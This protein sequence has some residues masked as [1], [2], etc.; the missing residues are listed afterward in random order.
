MSR[1]EIAALLEDTSV[2]A[3]Q[4]IN[5][6]SQGD[7]FLRGLIHAQGFDGLPH[8]VTKQEMNEY[9][10]AGERELFRGLDSYGMRGKTGEELAEQFRSGDLYTGLGLSGNGTYVAYG[11]DKYDAEGYMGADLE[12]AILR[13]TLKFEA[14]V[15]SIQELKSIQ[16]KDAIVQTHSELGELGRY[17]TFK[18]YDVIDVGASRNAPKY[19]VILNR[20]A[21]RVQN[22]SIKGVN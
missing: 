5:N 10:A 3:R 19:M 4:R 7:C 21:V 18:G 14:K 6:T 9:V 11:A 8:I 13:M 2:R 17:A 20:T 22:K 16:E 12:G 15:I 1:E